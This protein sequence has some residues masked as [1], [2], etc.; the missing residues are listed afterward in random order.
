MATTTSK[1]KKA[2]RLFPVNRRM[3]AALRK[4]LSADDIAAF[5]E[6][7]VEEFARPQKRLRKHLKSLPLLALWSES[8]VE[9]SGRERE[10]A[11][12]LDEM[13]AR[14][15]QDGRSKSRGKKKDKRTEAES[16][17][18][19]ILA[20]W[21]VESA[22]PPGPWESIVLAE[23]LLRESHRLSAERFTATLGILVDALLSESIG[24]LFEGSEA[25]TGS[26]DAI[27]QLISTGEMPWICSLLFS[28]LQAGPSLQKSARESLEKVLTESTDDDG[29]VHG[30]LLRR[31]PEWMAP[32]SRCAFWSAIFEQP[33]WS[34]EGHCRFASLIERST[35]F[36]L[37]VSHHH[38]EDDAP[39]L[40][41]PP[42]SQVLEFVLPLVGSEWE[43]RLQKMLKACQ[44]PASEDVPRLRKFKK[45]KSSEDTDPKAESTG[46]A[47]KTAASEGKL[48]LAGSWESDNSCVAI[49]RSGLDADSDVATLEWHS[50]DAQILLAAA[51]VPILTGHWDWSVKV[52]G[53]VIPGPATWKCSCWFLDPETIFVELEGED[54]A[55]VKRVRQ[56]LLA[57][58]DRFAI[59]TDS[60][61]TKDAD[62]KVELTTSVPLAEGTVCT[63]DAVTREL[64]LLNGPRTIRTFPI[65]ME[66]DR[67]QHAHGSYREQDGRL[68]LSAVG[69]G[70][71]VMPLAMDWHPKR[72]D[73]AADWA[74]LTVTEN[75]RTVG[76]HEACGFR[77]RIG[78]HQVLI[79]RSLMPPVISRAVLGLHTGD[80]SVYSRVPSKP[81]LLQPLVEV[82]TPE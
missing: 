76:S 41:S 67:I 72:S 59:L 58:H 33:V 56:L 34:D 50:S 73:A 6:A 29:I 5:H 57:P 64:S 14:Q 79:Y 55:P 37:P 8:H 39:E 52:D 24:G 53:E 28:P 54:S 40:L 13:T 60:V 46:A 36:V 18:E 69:Q 1:S 31:L 22:G 30:S 2:L 10:L 82:E 4:A 16:P 78:D 7:Y 26:S 15:S 65:W 70:G 9:L 71:V 3:S 20:N 21:L 75:R 81:A 32:L 43:S 74:R 35:L 19:E 48:K 61:T 49:L 44:K 77:I 38:S 45:K 66:D 17:Y 25:S 51:G 42:L 12:S 62:R 23:I 27:R 47:E 68:Q 63:A 11:A 80:E